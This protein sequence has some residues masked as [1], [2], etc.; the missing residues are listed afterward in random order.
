MS[1]LLV[2]ACN[3]VCFFGFIWAGQE[4]RTR[5]KQPRYSEN[6]LWG[7]R[8]WIIVNSRSSPRK[9]V[10]PGGRLLLLNV[11]SG[12]VSITVISVTVLHCRITQ[13]AEQLVRNECIILG[14]GGIKAS[15][16]PNLQEQ[17]RILFGLVVQHGHR[18][19]LIDLQVGNS[20]CRPTRS[21][22]LPSSSP[23]CV[24]CFPC[25]IRPSYG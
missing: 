15:D 18:V 6:C 1:P 12:H 7:R 2:L 24:Q 14:L 23:V 8:V 10:V 13:F 25:L 9:T 21:A 5:L 3:V 11:T 17:L 20:T 19:A 4:L 22:M 16:V